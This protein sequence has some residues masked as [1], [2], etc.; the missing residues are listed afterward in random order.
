MIKKLGH[1]LGTQGLARVTIKEDPRVP[2]DA[3]KGESPAP[4]GMM[5]LGEVAQYLRLHRSTVY[6]L[7][8]EGILPG[9]KAGNQWRFQKERVNQWM[10]E[11]EAASREPER[12]NP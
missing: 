3:K 7:A 6:R 9:F 8:R 1:G 2:K 10:A 11:Q 12:K 5:T 4:S